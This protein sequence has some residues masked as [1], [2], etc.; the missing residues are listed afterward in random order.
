MTHSDQLQHSN[1]SKNLSFPTIFFFPLNVL[2]FFTSILVEIIFFYHMFL[3]GLFLSSLPIFFFLF[4]FWTLFLNIWRNGHPNSH[5]T[6]NVPLEFSL[7]LLFLYPIQDR[8]WL[9]VKA[10]GDLIWDIRICGIQRVG[11]LFH[12][13]TQVKTCNTKNINEKKKIKTNTELPTKIHIYPLLE[14]FVIF[15]H[16]PPPN[17]IILLLA[18]V[19][20]LGLNFGSSFSGLIRI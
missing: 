20:G 11:W 5:I 16:P 14:Q 18:K 4:N 15:L 17:V 19:C 2:I 3:F 12:S 8:L 7:F 13:P 1:F 6:S 10:D 9:P